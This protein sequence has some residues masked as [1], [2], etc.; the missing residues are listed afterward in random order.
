[1][2]IFETNIYDVVMVIWG[3]LL[4]IALL[5]A[6]I[7]Y[8]HIQNKLKKD[9]LSKLNEHDRAV[10]FDYINSY[11]ICSKHLKKTEKKEQKNNAEKH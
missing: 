5:I 9:H 7:T 8:Y 6:C 3:T 1:M 11:S 2:K 4:L 10:I